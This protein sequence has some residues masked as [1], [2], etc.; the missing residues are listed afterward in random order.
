MGLREEECEC[1][2]RDSPG[3]GILNVLMNIRDSEYY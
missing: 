2:E 3:S 1:I